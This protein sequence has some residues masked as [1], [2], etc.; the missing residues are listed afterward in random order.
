MNPWDRMEDESPEIFRYFA[1]YRDMGPGRS[2]ARIRA[3]LPEAPQM[4]MLE[5]YS[6]RWGWVSRA[7]AFDDMVDKIRQ[8]HSARALAAMHERHAKQARDAQKVLSLPI[9]ALVKRMEQTGLEEQTL[10]A[11]AKRPATELIQLAT[12]ISTAMKDAVSIERQAQ[13]LAGEITVR[14]DPA[15]S[16]KS[17]LA[18]PMSTDEL[19]EKYGDAIRELA[20]DLRSDEPGGGILP[21]DPSESMDSD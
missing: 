17:Q 11:L 14:E 8:A 12:R 19:V 7:H 5:K 18:E 2:I 15:I 9:R 3:N 1:M 10:D 13:G 16:E 6:S 21:D 20:D 4:R